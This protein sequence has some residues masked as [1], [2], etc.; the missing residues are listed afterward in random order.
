MRHS[1]SSGLPRSLLY[2]WVDELPRVATPRKSGWITQGGYSPEEWMNHPGSLLPGRVDEFPR[3]ATPR[4]SGWIFQGRYSPEEW[5]KYPT[6]PYSSTALR[7]G[8]AP[9][10]LLPSEGEMHQ[11]YYCP[12]RGGCTNATTAL[13]WGG[14]TNATTALQGGDAPTLLPP[15]EGGMHQRYYVWNE[16]VK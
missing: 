9:T 5:M 16:I 2:E 7:E 10:L 12:P 4:K 13:R 3:V 14:C 15:S 11:R 6:N 1:C 8:D